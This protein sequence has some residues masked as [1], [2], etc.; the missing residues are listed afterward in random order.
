[1]YDQNE[2]IKQNTITTRASILPKVEAVPRYGDFIPIG[3]SYFGPDKKELNYVP[4]LGEN[5]D[6]NLF[7]AYKLTTRTVKEVES[8][9]RKSLS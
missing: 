3:Q 9:E 7:E 6:V 4:Y 8:L 1:V 5:V 2:I